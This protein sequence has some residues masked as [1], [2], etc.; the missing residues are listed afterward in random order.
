MGLAVLV[1]AIAGLVYVLTEIALRDAN[2]FFEMIED[3]E[4]FARAK[5]PAETVEESAVPGSAVPI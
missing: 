2:L 5:L 3:S 4:A 1:L